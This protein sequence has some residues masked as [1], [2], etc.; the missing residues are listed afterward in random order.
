MVVSDR[1]ARGGGTVDPIATLLRGLRVASVEV[2][3][4]GRI[5]HLNDS[6]SRLF[7][8][9]DGE[10]QGERPAALTKFRK[11][12]ADRLRI[13]VERPPNS[14]E[15][16]TVRFTG[17]SGRVYRAE[18]DVADDPRDVRRRILF[19]HDV[20]ELHELR[21]LRETLSRAL[22]RWR[23]GVGERAPL[24]ATTGDLPAPAS[25]RLT[26]Q[27]ERDRV[28]AALRATGHNRSEAARL[29]G[30]SR[31]TFYRRL[32]ALGIRLEE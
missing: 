1:T 30:V 18:V 9:A 27:D 13:M 22:A 3:A 17:G 28:R 24:G 32:G 7:G 6:A 11:G 19:F 29:L 26:E 2:D 16:L 15:S 4:K 14:R 23:A 12:D 21:R 25:P 20:S 8:R 5:E 10:L 31:A